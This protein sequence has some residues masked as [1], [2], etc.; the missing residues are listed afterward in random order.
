MS[1]RCLRI[2]DRAVFTKKITEKMV[3][4][5]A[6]LTGDY[7][8]IHVDK[9]F[10]ENTRFGRPI[11]HGLIAGSFISTVMGTELPGSGTIFL[12]QQIEFLLPVYYDDTITANVELRRIEEKH[13]VYIAELYG[14]CV[15]QREE[16]VCR[17]TAHQ[18]L[19][20]DFFVVES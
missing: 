16:I 17:A 3:L 9:K 1:K 8:K 15:N 5:F 2:G 12:D 14:E 4:A 13:S 7:S 20:K 19:P 18:M 10:A 6:E 11:A